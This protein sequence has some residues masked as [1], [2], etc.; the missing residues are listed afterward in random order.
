[1]LLEL[2]LTVIEEAERANCLLLKETGGMN[3]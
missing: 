2:V 3:V 1:M